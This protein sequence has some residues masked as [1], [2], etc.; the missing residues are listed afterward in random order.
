LTAADE[1]QVRIESGADQVEIP[2]SRIRRSN[3]EPDHA[4]P[5][6]GAR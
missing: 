1:R 4:T 5:L 2:L 3:L 6:E